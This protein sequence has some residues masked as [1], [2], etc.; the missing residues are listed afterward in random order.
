ML[1][2]PLA[3][4]LR[5][6]RASCNAR[7]DAAR[8]L[9]PHLDA[10]DFSL[11]LRDQ[12]SPLAA[13]LESRETS[14]VLDQAYELGLQLVAEKHAGPAAVRPEI[15]A[16]WMTVFPSIAKHIATAPRRIMGSLS[17]AAL[18]LTATPDMRP[19]IW[20]NRLVELGPRCANADQLLI[21]AQA[22]AWRAGLSHFR[23]SALAAVD[24][25]PPEFA[26]ETLEAPTG[27]N[28]PEVRDAHLSDPW[29][30]YQLPRRQ[31]LRI[32]A[33]RGFGGLFLTPPLVT[34]SG[35]QILVQS[36]G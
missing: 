31:D 36:G 25:L 9:R 6:R 4:F 32:G 7:F 1:A 8:R 20:R 11:F 24:S 3:D 30:G 12:L 19:K 18:H 16:L 33:F 26:L 15:N 14:A 10:G 21:V 29:F 28:W 13:S 27:S 23:V 34:Q 35:S 5:S 17:N 2:P 22:L